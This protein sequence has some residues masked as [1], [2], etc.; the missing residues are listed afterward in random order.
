M[1]PF[2]VLDLAPVVKGST[3]A[4]AFRNTLDL[5]RHVEALGFHRYWLAEHHNMPGIAS[6][7]TA[8]V[9]AHVAGGTSRMR[10]GAGGI[11]LP[12]HPPLVIAEQFGTL[13]SLYPGRI[14]LGLG[15]APGTDAVTTRALRRDPFAGAETFP[16]DV[17]ELIGY[18]ASP[19]QGQKVRAVPGAGL[20]VPVW[21][22][23]SSLYSAELATRMGLPFAFASH[24]APDY[25]LA[26][27]DSYR[28]YFQP[29][30]RLQ[31]PYAMAA[32]NVVA[33]PTDEEARRLF[34]SVQQQFINLRRGV[35]G[36]LQDPAE[37]DSSLWTADDRAAVSHVLHYAVVGAPAT[38]RAGLERFLQLT[39]VD[40]LMITA[41]VFDHDARKRS[42]TIVADIHASLAA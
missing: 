31:A 6:S 15:R 28:R 38:A 17:R 27:L 42:F 21:L 18:F 35:P 29:S 25:L 3:P 30:A 24:F 22:L 9:I 12:N 37:I 34:T 16:D 10:V 36:R 1:P 32:I 39:G 19:A 26:A 13:E 41:H 40:E 23:G 14:D 11:M 5:A 4:Q 33:A 8:V 2:S 7:A 20:Q